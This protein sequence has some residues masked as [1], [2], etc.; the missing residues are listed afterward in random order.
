MARWYL[1]AF[2]LRVKVQARWVCLALVCKISVPMLAVIYISCLWALV[3]IRLLRL[4]FLPLSYGTLLTRL[5]CTWPCHSACQFRHSDRFEKFKPL[6]LQNETHVS[7]RRERWKYLEI[8]FFFLSSPFCPAHLKHIPCRRQ[9]AVICS[10]RKFKHLLVCV[11]FTKSARMWGL[12][13]TGHVQL[14]QCAS[15][16]RED[17]QSRFDLLVNGKKWRGIVPQEVS[18]YVSHAM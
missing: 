12:Y 9:T 15:L 14:W 10:T 4:T 3:C 6:P 2:V 8:F 18:A 16:C 1:W 13:L 5:E 7:K 11:Q 17:V